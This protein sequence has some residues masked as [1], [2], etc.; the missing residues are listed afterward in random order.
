[1]LEKRHQISKKSQEK[2]LK[3]VKQ[4]L[5]YLE[6]QMCQTHANVKKISKVISQ[7]YQTNVKIVKAGEN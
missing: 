6:M 7:I 2:C 1:M 4:I 5:M 3:D